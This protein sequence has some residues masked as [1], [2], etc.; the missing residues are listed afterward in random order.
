MKSPTAGQIDISIMLMIAKRLD[1]AIRNF[2]VSLGITK[3]IE[4]IA[5]FD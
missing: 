1:L 2:S 3:Q 4:V 5:W